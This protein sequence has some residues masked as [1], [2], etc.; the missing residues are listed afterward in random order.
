VL[1]G[2][3]RCVS[4]AMALAVAGA[5]LILSETARADGALAPIWTGVYVGAQGG[6]DWADLD[7]NFDS[8]FST[9]GATGGGHV[10][11]NW[12]V[13]GLIVGVEA[14]A[15]VANA[16]FSATGG[17]NTTFDTGW[18]GTVRGRAGIPVGPALYYATM[19]YAWS[20]VSITSKSIGGGTFNESH[21]FDGIVYGVGAEA[22]VL[23]N[24]SVRLE[25][26]HF[27]YSSDQISI[28]GVGPAAEIDPS[29][30]VVR[31]GLTFHLN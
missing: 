17:N 25:A 24:L 1:Y 12:G 28:A 31:A 11:F 3:T 27:D 7:T 9:R 18:S 2:R 20:D 14:D 29:D 22:Y 23:P 30:T 19:G 4:A 10:G 5:P 21:R 15:N 26:L 13:G 6:I 8:G 16:Q